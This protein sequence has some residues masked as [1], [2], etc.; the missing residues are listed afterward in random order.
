VFI[1]AFLWFYH[2]P[3]SASPETWDVRYGSEGYPAGTEP[4]SLLE[5]VLP[6]LPAGRALDLASGAGRNAVFLATK[7]WRVVGIDSSRAALER[8]EALGKGRGVEV[9]RITS[10]RQEY[11]T[12]LP[13]LWLLEANLEQVN[14]P[15]AQFE[16]VICFHYLQRSLFPAIER[17]LRPGGMLVYETYTLEQLAFP[18]GP[19]NPEYLLKPGELRDALPGL[20]TLF[21]REFCTGKGMASLVARKR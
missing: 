1:R 10:L 8:T 6:M 13:I 18:H 11:R 9:N 2:L 17:A 16:L 3:M 15:A 14:L 7:G 19:H 4:A 5:Q 20:Q 12:G 21:Y